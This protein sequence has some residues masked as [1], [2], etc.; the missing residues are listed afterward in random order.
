MATAPTDIPQYY[1]DWD[2]A[3]AQ[4]QGA[5]KVKRASEEKRGLGAGSLLP[6]I[7]KR[8]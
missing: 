7:V 2:Q 6:A 1:I 4:A 5:R 3:A 8:A